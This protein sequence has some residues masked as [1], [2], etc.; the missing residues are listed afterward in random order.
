MCSGSTYMADVYSLLALF[1]LQCWDIVSPKSKVHRNNKMSK[2]A[3]YSRP[4]PSSMLQINGTVSNIG[5]V[6]GV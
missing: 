6:R 4:D 2:I 3:T 5:Q 1:Y